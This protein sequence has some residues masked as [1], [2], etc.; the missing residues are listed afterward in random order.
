MSDYFSKMNEDYV[1]KHFP[2]GSV[3]ANAAKTVKRR[4]MAALVFFL[5]FLAGGLCGL[6]WGSAGRWNSCP[7]DRTAC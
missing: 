1:Q 7:R 2:T 5:V 4:G 6:A 3:F